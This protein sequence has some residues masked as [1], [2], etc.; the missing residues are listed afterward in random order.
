MLALVPLTGVPL[1][2]ISYGGSAMIATLSGLGLV[3]NVSRYQL[4]PKKK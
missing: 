2:L 3:L 1:P 4:S